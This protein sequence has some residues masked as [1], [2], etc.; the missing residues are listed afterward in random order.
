MNSVV[1][2]SFLVVFVALNANANYLFRQNGQK[3]FYHEKFPLTFS[4]GEA[5]CKSIGGNLPKLES[6]RDIKELSDIIMDNRHDFV[7]GFWLPLKENDDGRLVWADGSSFTPSLAIIK[8]EIGCTRD[9]CHYFFE[10]RDKQIYF[11]KHNTNVLC[12]MPK[13]SEKDKKEL[14]MLKK[15]IKAL[16]DQVAK[17]A[18]TIKKHVS[19]CLDTEQATNE[20]LEGIQ[21]IMKKLGNQVKN[22]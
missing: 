6:T 13:E 11:T 21:E 20:S 19:Q 16:D 14:D 2:C 15:E 8:K 3:L 12:V 10:A 5:Y 7:S 17:H 18:L 9:K 1:S 4:E 22:V